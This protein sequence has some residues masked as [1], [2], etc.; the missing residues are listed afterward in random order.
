[1]QTT[2]SM[3]PAGTHEAYWVRSDCLDAAYD[4]FLRCQGAGGEDLMLYALPRRT[5][6]PR[7]AERS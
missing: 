7:T 6:I 5:P 3:Q 4:L 2:D 1:M